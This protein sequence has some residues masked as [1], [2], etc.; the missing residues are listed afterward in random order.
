V[1]CSIVVCLII[2]VTLVPGC[3]VTANPSPILDA[4]L[5]QLMENQKN[6]GEEITHRL[7]EAEDAY[8]SGSISQGEY[9][10]LKNNLLKE[11]DDYVFQNRQQANY[12]QQQELDRIR[13]R[14]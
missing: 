1:G 6:K 12:Y 9:L 3:A 5:D 13:S 10:T 4:Q 11:Y 2:C 7:Q 8:K 14:R